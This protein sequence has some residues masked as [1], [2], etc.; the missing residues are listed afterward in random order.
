MASRQID[1]NT[2]S[3]FLRRRLKPLSA[4]AGAGLSARAF[5]R[6]SRKPRLSP[7]PRRRTASAELRRSGRQSP[8]GRRERQ[9]EVRGG[10]GETADGIPR[11]RT[12]RKISRDFFDQFKRNQPEK[13]PTRAQGSGFLISADGYVVTNHHVADKADEIEVTFENDEKYKAKVVGSD[14][15]TDI[16]L[17]KIDT[18][19]GKF[20]H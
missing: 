11:Y 14:A 2:G 19:K 16:A 12:C 17:L 5:W 7:R 10:A 1:G 13:H 3:F 9:R 18:K 6:R 4:I 15:R 8:P 20:D